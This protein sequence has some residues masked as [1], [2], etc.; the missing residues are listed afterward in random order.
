MNI[1]IG[2][3]KISATVSSHGAELRSLKDERGIEYLWC[4]DPAYWNRSAPLLFPIVG[5]L[6]EDKTLIDGREYVIPKHGFS[7]DSDFSLLSQDDD[8]CEFELK[9]SS[10][11]K[12]MYPYDF[13]LRLRYKLVGSSVQVDYTVQ[14]TGV[15]R[16]LYCLG[17]HPAFLCEGGNIEQAE[18]LFEQTETADCP[19]LT[20]RI[21]TKKMT[22]VLDHSDRLLLTYDLFDND[23]LIFTDLK[24]R[25][26]RL[27]NKTPGA[28]HRD[29]RVDFEGFETLGIWTPAGKKAP[30]I[31]IEPWNGMACR[32]DEGP[33]F[34]DKHGI[35]RL[36]PGRAENYRLTFALI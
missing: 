29:V 4:A 5:N 14:N 15:S 1:E 25:S 22:R 21:E 30:F 13:S 28:E 23:A 24:S 20:S 19:L 33:D 9:S 16:M 17:A 31:C 3:G 10:G 26:V 18:I 36:E 11:T 7:R 2:N 34:A 27:H 35:K 6:A 8:S 32:D 12:T